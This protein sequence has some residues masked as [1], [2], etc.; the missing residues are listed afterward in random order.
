VYQFIY[1]ECEMAGIK[2]TIIEILGDM[3]RI[4]MKYFKNKTCFKVH[5]ENVVYALA[6]IL[7]RSTVSLSKED[8]LAVSIGFGS[9]LLKLTSPAIVPIFFEINS[10][11]YGGLLESVKTFLVD[12]IITEEVFNANIIYY[13]F[14]FI[15]N[16]H[17]RCKFEK[18]SI[19]FDFLERVTREICRN[20]ENYLRSLMKKV[21]KCSTA[22][23][24]RE[25]AHLRQDYLHLR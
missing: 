15:H 12:H 1:Q 6:D 3:A 13:F 17:V 7:E 8:L 20:Y 5:I 25:G 21:F 14:K 24:T 11:I 22:Q 16:L 23:K 9:N 4:H 2:L 10:N 18:T 19:P